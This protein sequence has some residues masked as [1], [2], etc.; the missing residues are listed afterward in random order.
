MKTIK[1]ISL[2]VFLLASDFLISQ[3]TNN[4]QAP[5]SVN[6]DGT[7]PDAS[8][9]L[10]VQSIDKGM[11]VPRMTTAQ[12]EAIVSP[13]TGLLLYDTD[14]G[15]FWYFNGTIWTNLSSG[16]SPIST[17][18]DA[19][20]NSKIQTEENPNEDIIRFDVAGT[21]MARL[22]GKTFHLNAPGNSLFIGMDAGIQDDSTDNWNTFVGLAVGDA[23]TSGERNSFFGFDT[24]GSNTTGNENTFI[25]TEAGFSNTIGSEN[26][27]VGD[28]AGFSTTIGGQ[29][30]YFGENA[31]GLNTIG[32]SNT[33]I[34]AFAGEQNTE[35]SGNTFLGR[36][37]GRNNTGSGNVFIG[38]QAGQD[39]AGSNKLYIENSMVDSAGALIYGEFDNDLVAINGKL[40][41]GTTAPAAHLQ[42]ENGAVVFAGSIGATPVSGSGTRLMWVPEKG[43]FRAG[44]ACGSEWNDVNIGVNS[45]VVGGL[46]NTASS[47]GAFVAGGQA[48]NATNFATFC[49]G[50][51]NT[52]SGNWSFAGGG[53]QNSAS[54]QGAFVAGG[55]NNSASGD[56]SFVC[57]GTQCQAT[58][59]NAFS[60]GVNNFATGNN[61][62]IGGGVELTAKSYGETV[63]GT[64]NT[65]YSPNSVSG[66]NSAD[67]LF[68]IGNGDGSQNRSNAL[69]VLKNGDTGIGTD[70][71]THPLHMG[72]GAHCTA[73]GTW[74]NASDRRLKTDIAGLEYGL[75]KIM[76]LRPVSYRMKNGGEN[77]VGFIA[78]EVREV[79]PELVSGVE[80]SIEKGETLGMS[81]GNLTA[82]LVKAV[83]E[84]QEEIEN[85]KRRTEGLEN[86]V[87]EL[88]AKLSD[89]EN[90]MNQ[91]FSL[92]GEQESEGQE[93][94]TQK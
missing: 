39:Q 73:A 31:G 17:I 15:G 20:G 68:V 63:F 30:V 44:D 41:I 69:T 93:T 58:G 12:R 78:Q 61:S 7:A 21:E 74:T 81:Y 50:Y 65:D 83:Q 1:L 85:G 34:G 94:M 36:N 16:S 60:S 22:D 28:Q 23:N 62:F 18:A 55:D 53:W 92:L 47:D 4:L 80:G 75:G 84:Q 77:Q 38:D 66:I 3:T 57:A 32:M 45:A 52:A 13:S 27:F 40:G 24:G 71:P 56:Y 14:T 5:T 8:A 6:T 64:Y 10:D 2:A 11:L 72:S 43:A 54:G 59:N 67:R 26:T 35:G 90:K 42:V 49:S 29:N 76:S 89:M 82:V 46:C 48:N 33:A 70:T 91:V 9:M 25:G 87:A 19:D 51:V 88:Q 79:L 86:E 37:A